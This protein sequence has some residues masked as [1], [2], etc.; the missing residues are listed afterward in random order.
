MTCHRA[1]P[2]A[3][4]AILWPAQIIVLIIWDLSNMESKPYAK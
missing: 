1:G 2:L 3:Y 4:L